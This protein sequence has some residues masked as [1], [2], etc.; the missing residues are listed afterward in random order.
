MLLKNCY[1]KVLT[2]FLFFISLFIIS[3]SCD[4]TEPTDEL[5]QGRRDYTWTV[6]TINSYAYY[7]MWGSSPT[8]LWAT[9]STDWENSIGNFDGYQ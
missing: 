2:G 7:R 1:K 9:G 4:S 6:D 8:D 5:K 3:I